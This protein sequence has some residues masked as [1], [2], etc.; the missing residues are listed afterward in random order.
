MVQIIFYCRCFHIHNE[1]TV[2]CKYFFIADA[3]VYTMRLQCGA[4]II[5]QMLPYT[6]LQCGTNAIEYTANAVIYITL[7][8]CGTN[9]IILKILS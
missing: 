5:L 9:A 2:W 6:L 1:I 3:S 7:L 4:N 8:P